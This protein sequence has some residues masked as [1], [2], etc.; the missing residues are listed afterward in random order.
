MEAELLSGSTT[1]PFA[2]ASVP[3]PSLSSEGE[4]Q[5]FAVPGLLRGM[6]S[7]TAPISP[8]ASPPA[9]LLKVDEAS[10]AVSAIEPSYLAEIA[11]FCIPPKQIRDVLE[12]V[13]ELLGEHD[14]T[15]TS[16]RRLLSQPCRMITRC[17]R[18]IDPFT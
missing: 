4:G 8:A 3:C 6:E 18:W 5:P 1:N 12:A 14:T 11:E 2:R 9:Y 13:L 10:R 7:P 16:M 17:G 15:W